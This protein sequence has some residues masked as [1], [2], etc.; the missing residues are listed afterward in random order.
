MLLGE[1]IKSSFEGTEL[2]QDVFIS[3]GCETELLK[4]E[5]CSGVK[6]T[7]YG[8]KKSNLEFSGE[9]IEK[10]ESQ[11]QKIKLCWKQF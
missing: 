11:R 4:L 8:R 5:A 9:H 7:S 1:T 10:L 3:Y 6:A 2:A